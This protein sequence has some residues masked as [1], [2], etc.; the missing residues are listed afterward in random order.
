MNYDI[1]QIL[2]YEI[3]REIAERYFGFRKVIEEDKQELEEKVRQQSFILEKRIVFDLIRIYALLDDA[4]LIREFLDLCSLDPALFYDPILNDSKPIR[5]R[6]LEGVQTRG[7]TR[8]GRYQLL[9]LDCYERLAGH[10]LLYRK[11]FAELMEFRSVIAEEIRAFYRQ[12]DLGSI[13]GFL[14][15]LGRS[16]SCSGLV[17]GMEPGMANELEK[18]M[19]IEPPL[20]IEQYLP[21]VESLPDPAKTARTLKKLAARAWRLH[22]GTG[23]AGVLDGS[24]PWDRFFTSRIRERRR[25]G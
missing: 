24:K 17:G 11:N 4:D 16:D 19:L 1:D 23:L 6:V 8:R 14:R 5:E 10:V 18:K 15:S 3:K 22:G 12:N 21:V 7:F 25:G 2:A 9:V 20:P 13:L